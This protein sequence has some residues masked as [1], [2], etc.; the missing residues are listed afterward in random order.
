M[1]SRVAALA[2]CLFL[3]A[4]SGDDP[5]P[6]QG[7]TDSSVDSNVDSTA[8]DSNVDSSAADSNVD[9]SAVDSSV[10]SAGDVSGDAGESSALE[11][12]GSRF[13][14]RYEEVEW[15][16][17]AKSRRFVSFWDETRKEDCIVRE[18]GTGQY[19]CL[20]T[21][22]APQLFNTFKDAACTQSVVARYKAYATP[23]DSYVTM[24]AACSPTI[25]KLG[26]KL[27]ITTV[28]VKNSAGAC[29][30]STTSGVI[31]DTWDTPTAIAAS[32][33][34]AFTRSIETRSFEA[35]V[36]GTRLV[37]QGERFSGPDG[38]FESRAPS[39]LDKSRGS[40]RGYPGYALDKTLRLLPSAY[41][42]TL[43]FGSTEF[44]DASCTKALAGFTK[45]PTCSVDPAQSLDGVLGETVDGCSLTR[46]YPRPTSSPLTASYSKSSGTC[47]V[48][49]SY[50]TGLDLYPAS[51]VVE[52]LA[53]T[54]AGLTYATTTLAFQATTA[55]SV[56]SPSLTSADGLALRQRSAIFVDKTRFVACDAKTTA[57]G[58]TRC[59]PL[60]ASL[61]GL[62]TW[63]SDATC[64]TPVVGFQ[65]AASFPCSIAPPATSLGLSGARVFVRPTSTPLTPTKVYEKDGSGTCAE[66]LVNPSSVDVYPRTPLT[67]LPATS[68]TERTALR[69]V[70]AR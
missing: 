16:D 42:V 35:E 69:T 23:A 47:A 68:F 32:E 12:S 65:R 67:E 33:F 58:K 52:A 46:V 6:D 44:S 24:G 55:L 18:F 27:G 51:S 39:I 30:V 13:T 48:S 17:G 25:G 34:G 43:D 63:Y 4:C 36:S 9:S 60:A 21:T 56:Q 3:V 53:S 66:A 31:L 49:G 26:A 14:A 19:R 54:F 64:T 8:V 62:D 61:V 20:P 29:V 5:A 10:D 40:T 11:S 45:P 2:H 41:G 15:A 57:D 59:I 50:T 37:L 1:S 28:Y 7:S 70:P 22:V 38:S